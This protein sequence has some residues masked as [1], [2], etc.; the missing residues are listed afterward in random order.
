M[1]S[2]SFE[3]AGFLDNRSYCDELNQTLRNFAKDNRLVI[4]YGASDDLMEFDGS[5]Y[6]EAGVSDGDVV[7]VNMK[8]I[9]KHPECN[10]EY[11]DQH[12]M[13]IIK[14]SIPIE[15]HQDYNPF[16]HYKT[17]IPH[18]KFKIMEDEDIY[19]EGIVFSLD[20]LESVLP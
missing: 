12:H 3:L 7:Y 11:A 20:D 2:T 1:K 17:V 9:V 19:C 4:V 10:C 8:G 15:V 6:D 14:K 18:A 16:W 5:W 13:S